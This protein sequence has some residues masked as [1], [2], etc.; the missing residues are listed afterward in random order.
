MTELEKLLR[1]QKVWNHHLEKV[2]NEIGAGAMEYRPMPESNSAAWILLHMID[3][4]RDFVELS[5]PERAEELIGDLPR[6]SEREL[7]RMSL[8]R[9]IALLEA[10]RVAFLK[11][12]ERL[13]ES[14]RLDGTC[15]AGEGKSWMDLIHSVTAHEVYHCGQLAYLARV[16][17]QKARAAREE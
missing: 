14:G 16:L 17:Q 9:I 4:Y 6:P 2:C 8:T 11:E 15:P 3:N 10:H 7:A 13:S 1:R 12:V 5:G